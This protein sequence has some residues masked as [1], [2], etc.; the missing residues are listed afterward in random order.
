MPLTRS[1]RQGMYR[2]LWLGGLFAFAVMLGI[3]AASWLF[4]STELR[5]PVRNQSAIVRLPQP[6]Q[7]KARIAN[8]LDILVRGEV[9]SQVPINQVIEVPIQDTLHTIIS[10]DHAV[11]VKMDVPLNVTIP[12]D[13]ILHVDSTV[14]VKVLGQQLS[15][16]IR[17]DIPVKAQIPLKLNVP[18]D[19]QVHLKFVAPA[20]ATLKQTLKIPLKTS[21][22]ARI[23][24]QGAMQ[25]PVKSD[26]EA[27]VIISQPIPA[28]I[29]HSDLTIP[30]SQL[31][32]QRLR[33]A[34]QQP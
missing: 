9:Q 10:F 15:L 34:R 32:L 26:L 22:D 19:Q 11:P 1:N 8:D 7:A 20:D 27:Q 30:L 24:I 28:V 12:L 17:G 21:I 29:S 6:I 13:Q 31:G 25:V 23:P 18:V 14:Q 2:I 33:S 5:L 3:G 16:P 4:K